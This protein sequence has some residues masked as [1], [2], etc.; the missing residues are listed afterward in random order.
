MKDKY[1]ILFHGVVMFTSVTRAC[2]APSVIVTL[3]LS[4]DPL[5]HNTLGHNQPC[6]LGEFHLQ[7]K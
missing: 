5:D 4:E 2:C 3:A 1:S 6:F 7:V